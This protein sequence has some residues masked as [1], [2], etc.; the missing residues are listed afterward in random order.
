MF[1]ARSPAARPLPPALQRIEGL[2]RG[3]ALASGSPAVPTGWAELDRALGGG[4]PG[5]RLT[6]IVSPGGGKASLLFAMAA[7]ATGSGRCVAWVD[8]RSALD[9]RGAEAAG[10]LLDRVLWVRP[11][12]VAQA[13][14]A[15]DLVLGSEGFAFVVL[16]L[17]GA[18]ERLATG[19][20]LPA[21]PSPASPGS[22]T[23]PGSRASGASPA[24][25]SRSPGRARP[26]ADDRVLLDGTAWNRLARRAEACDVAL[27]VCTERPMAGGAASLGLEARVVTPTWHRVSPGGP[28][29]LEGAAVQVVVR[30]R[31]N[32]QAGFT[33]AFHAD[34]PDPA[35]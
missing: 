5:G 25:R 15:A 8:P 28:L 32:G 24:F 13:F 11:A 23:F 27:V 26:G 9:I 6:E 18:G 30:H 20:S 12:T 31:K 34:L 17:V 3:S 35:P 29:T 22:L 2:K 19:A 7:V 33:G 10:V 14:R 1:E 4:L 21:M 16:D